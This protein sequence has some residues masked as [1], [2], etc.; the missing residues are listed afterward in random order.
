MQGLEPVSQPEFKLF[1]VN[2]IR[3]RRNTS[4]TMQKG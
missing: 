1:I 2:R 4:E 3:E